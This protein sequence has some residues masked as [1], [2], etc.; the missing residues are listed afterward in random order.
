M[1]SRRAAWEAQ[2]A[3]SKL[4]LLDLGPRKTDNLFSA[5]RRVYQQQLS[6]L[7]KEWLTEDLQARRAAYVANRAAAAKSSQTIDVGA[8]ERAAAREAAREARAAELSAERER[9]AK[10]KANAQRVSERRTVE[11]EKAQD[12]YLRRWI[13]GVL[14]EYD[15]EGT[16]TTL[17]MLQGTRSWLHPENFE[18]RLHLLLMQSKSPVEKWNKIARR[19]QADEEREALMERLGG[20]MLPS[21]ASLLAPYSDDSAARASATS[22]LPSPGSAPAAPSSAGVGGAA[23]AAAASTSSSPP[24]A[25]LL[26]ADEEFLVDLAKVI[27]DLG[28]PPD[29]PKKG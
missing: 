2:R 17:P 5:D 24:D 22:P 25:G 18:K 11:R 29:P 4:R 21:D 12:E 28:P 26:K 19:L 10:E 13:Q 23:A 9:M 27:E 20:R 16:A 6:D 7:R 14:K 15:V 8:V 1:S 3:V